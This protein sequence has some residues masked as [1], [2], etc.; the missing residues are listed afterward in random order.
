MKVLILGGSGMVG[1]SLIKK[2]SNKYEIFSLLRERSD[3]DSNQFF[4]KVLPKNQCIFIDDINEYENLN[5]IVKKILPDGE[6]VEFWK[7]P[8]GNPTIIVEE[9]CPWA[10][11][12]YDYHKYPFIFNKK[13]T[14]LHTLVKYNDSK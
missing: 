10:S 7:Y 3:L 12:F 8:F 5:N 9:E 2:L 13:G 1:H 14:I 11:K 6:T 4:E